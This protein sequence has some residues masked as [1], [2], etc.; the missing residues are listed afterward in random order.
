MTVKTDEKLYIDSER[1]AMLFESIGL[2][3][4]LHRYYSLRLF[5]HTMIIVKVEMH[6]VPIT[7]Y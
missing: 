1:Y 3:C 6:V 2:V 5:L 4:T 7:L